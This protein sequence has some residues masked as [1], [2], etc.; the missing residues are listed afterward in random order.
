MGIQLKTDK[1]ERNYQLMVGNSDWQDESIQGEFRGRRCRPM[2]NACVRGTLGVLLAFTLSA[3]IIVPSTLMCR[4]VKDYTGS[5]YSS[6]YDRVGCY[7][8]VGF[9]G[10][11]LTL[12]GSAI[13][14]GGGCVLCTPTNLKKVPLVASICGE[15]LVDTAKS[16]PKGVLDMFCP[17]AEDA[18]DAELFD[19]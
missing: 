12:L 9:L 3:A 19:V 4:D 7:I 8:L 11:F 1:T 15:E 16:C 14:L 18:E 5:D 6:D 13:V 10:S 2:D 17:R